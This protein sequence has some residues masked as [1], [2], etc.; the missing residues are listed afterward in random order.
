MGFD[1][2]CVAD[3]RLGIAEEEQ[4]NQAGGGV[5]FGFEGGEAGVD[6]SPETVGEVRFGLRS[7]P[8]PR[9]WSIS[10]WGMVRIMPLWRGPTPRSNGVFMV[11]SAPVPA[12]SVRRL[13]A[14]RNTSEP[15][16]E[17]T[18]L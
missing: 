18:N 13:P 4:A 7:A 16:V 2:A 5:A 17:M 15:R 3:R 10:R 12:V 11:N 9:R 6:E 14:W 8:R 1:L